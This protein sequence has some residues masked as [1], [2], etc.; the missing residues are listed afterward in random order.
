M[1]SKAVSLCEVEGIEIDA[2]E[3]IPGL[4]MSIF[5]AVPATAETASG[6][7]LESST[8]GRP[9]E[10]M[11]VPGELTDSPAGPSS[12]P[13]SPRS[14]FDSILANRPALVMVRS[15]VGCP[16]AGWPLLIFT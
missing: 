15:A 12:D 9:Y 16:T 8:G 13:S 7:E 11:P 14:S 1:R 5:S 3:S 4:S 10:A 2:D 6:L